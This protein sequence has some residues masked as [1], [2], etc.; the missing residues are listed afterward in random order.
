VKGSDQPRPV[1][2]EVLQSTSDVLFPAE[3][4]ERIV[5]VSTRG[6]EGDTPLHVMAWRGDADGAGILIDAG[7]DVDAIGDMGEVPLHIAIRSRHL[8]LVSLLLGAG[9][10]TDILS[11]FGSTPVDLAKEI[12]GEVLVLITKRSSG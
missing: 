12:G 2:E 11:E 7:A 1:L 8:R 5:T 10:R 9:A 3:A 6:V 4:G